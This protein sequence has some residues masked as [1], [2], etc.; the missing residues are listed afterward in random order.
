MAEK[1]VALEAMAQ[2]KILVSSMALAQL[3][4]GERGVLKFLGLTS[5]VRRVFFLGY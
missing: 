4:E 5:H 2:M 1:V 3:Q